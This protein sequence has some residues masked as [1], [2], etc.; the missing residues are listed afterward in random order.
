MLFRNSVEFS[1][2][3]FSLLQELKEHHPPID[4]STMW[5]LTGPLQSDVYCWLQRRLQH[6]D[7]LNGKRLSWELLY[8]Q[9]GRG[10]RLADFVYR[11]KQALDKVIP[12]IKSD[13]LEFQY[14]QEPVQ[15][16]DDGIVLHNVG[17]QVDAKLKKKR[18][19]GW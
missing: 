13:Y 8:D 7:T 4:K 3:F 16:F 12:V 14:Q 19:T 15:V 11:F 10:Q 5:G 18:A 9:F 17:Q 6:H 2:Q 1:P